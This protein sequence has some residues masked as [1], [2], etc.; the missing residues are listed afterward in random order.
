V[1]A[2]DRVSTT[3]E[4]SMPLLLL[5]LLILVPTVP[6][7]S[8]TATG[9]LP[10]SPAVSAPLAAPDAP[11]ATADHSAPSAPLVTLREAEAAEGSAAQPTV[12]GFLY[13]V[14]LTA[15]TALVTALVWRA[16]F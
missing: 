6:L 10:S 2:A 16:V 3:L 14:F 5:L 1:E 13:H 15:V 12:Q 8:Q 4:G 9:D 7:A 11:A